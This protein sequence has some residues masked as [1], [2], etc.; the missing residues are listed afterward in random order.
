MDNV[1][2]NIALVQTPLIWESPKENRAKFSKKFKEL[3]QNTDLVILPEMFITGFTMTPD[4]V[5]REEGQK[6]IDWMLKEAKTYDTAIMGSIPFYDNG[7]FY[8]RLFFVEANGTVSQYDKRHT[9]TLAGEDKVYTS[10]T[11]RLI[12]GYKGFRVYPL[13]CYDL[14]FPVWARNNDDYDVLVY[15]AN[16]PKPRILAWDT[17]LKARAIENMSYCVGVNR[18]GFDNA[19]YE[20][21]GH[22]A[23]YDCLGEQIVFAETETILY[24]TL[25]K[26]HVS[27]TRGKLKFLQDRDGFTLKS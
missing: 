4:N 7:D 22:S 20:Y 17:L 6:T 24:A 2:L 16:W 21:S 18:C 27:K 26:N 12:M 1:E 19:G 13:I 11:E 3:P 23:V 5:D 8:N 15:V 25:N 10:G 14:R 9:F